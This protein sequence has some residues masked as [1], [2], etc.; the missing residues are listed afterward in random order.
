VVGSVVVVVNSVDDVVDGTYDYKKVI[1]YCVFR[2]MM[3]RLLKT[4]RFE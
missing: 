2:G 3:F 4:A 1:S